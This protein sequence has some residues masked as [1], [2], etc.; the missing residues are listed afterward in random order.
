M[1]LASLVTSLVTIA[2]VLLGAAPFAVA[3]TPGLNVDSITVQGQAAQSVADVQLRL[4][5]AARS[6]AA[7]LQARQ[8][9]A[10]STELTLPPGAMVVLVSSND[11]RITLHPGARFVVGTVTLKGETHQALSGLIDVQVKRALDYFNISYDKFT[12]AVKG[13][14]FS[15]E[16][17]PASSLRFSVTEGV[18]EVER[19]A[20]IRIAGAP[21]GVADPADAAASPASLSNGIRIVEDLKA[22]QSKRYQLN[23]S[24]YLDEFKNFSDVEA[25]FTQALSEAQASGDKRRIHRALSNLMEA[26][27]TMARPKAVLDLQGRC[28]QVA[29]Q[30]ASPQHEAACLGMAG[31]AHYRLGENRQSIE[32]HE[33]ALALNERRS[34]GR[35]SLAVASNLGNLG[36]NYAVLG[37]TSK[38]MDYYER[39]LAIK[40]RLYAGRDQANIAWSLGA[41]G[42]AHGRLGD[43]RKAIGYYDKA[44]AMNQRLH[45]NRDHPSITGNLGS[46][47]IAYG[48][49]G[50]NRKAIEYY[51]KAL[52]MNRRLYADGDHPDIA[53]N[54]GRLGLAHGALGDH[55]K[56]IELHETALAMRERM[57]AG[58]DHRDIATSLAFL[59]D[60]HAKAG[61]KA[62]AAAYLERADAMKARLKN[63]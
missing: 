49:L 14:R 8:V 21:L 32:N 22:G 16:I 42:Y 44:L 20:Q 6:Q 35:D 31:N 52:A 50:D 47:G 37:E 63:T 4:P 58:R 18:V 51:D 17:D 7:T 24:E 23:L 10:P 43:H 62:E 9:L 34:A 40:E 53:G 12:A 13:T 27:L 56:A 29:Q 38:A 30:L 39:S 33:K 25:Y 57:S 5:G 61:N 54:F 26:H 2:G 45:P 28:L 60:A 55:R 41:I 1:P 46:L 15:V 36:N 19:P 59:A 11:N 48:A 3:Q